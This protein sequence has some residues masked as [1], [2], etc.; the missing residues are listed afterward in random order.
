MHGQQEC[1]VKTFSQP[2]KKWVPKVAIV[3]AQTTIHKEKCDSPPFL[4]IVRITGNN[5]HNWLVDLGAFG[6]VMPYSVC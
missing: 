1:L 5:L 4:L 3:D 2:Q 6:N